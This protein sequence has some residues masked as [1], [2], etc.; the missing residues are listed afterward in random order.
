[1][2]AWQSWALKGLGGGLLGAA[3]FGALYYNPDLD[4]KYRWQREYQQKLDAITVQFD[5]PDSAKSYR[6]SMTDIVQFAEDKRPAMAERMPM[7]RDVANTLCNRVDDLRNVTIDLTFGDGG[8]TSYAQYAVAIRK[9]DGTTAQ[10]P[11]VASCNVLIPQAYSNVTDFAA[12][13]QD[14]YAQR[15]DQVITE[16]PLTDRQKMSEKLFSFMKPGRR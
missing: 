5:M 11:D 10:L 8:C 16:P 15:Q 2:K 14:A 1:M 12:S 3:G 9:T 6:F 4:L 7:L 13:A